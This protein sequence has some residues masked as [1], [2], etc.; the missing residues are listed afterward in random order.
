MAWQ[1]NSSK[2]FNQ[3]MYYGKVIKN[4]IF[5]F[6]LVQFEIFYREKNIE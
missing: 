6:F 4:V 2:P 5:Y 1:G 3:I